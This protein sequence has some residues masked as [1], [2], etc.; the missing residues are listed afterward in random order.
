MMI[1]A[2][3]V[4]PFR[5]L[6]LIHADPDPLQ[7]VS[8]NQYQQM[9]KAIIRMILA[10]DVAYLGRDNRFP[11]ATDWHGIRTDRAECAGVARTRHHTLR[12]HLTEL[13]IFKTKMTAK[14]F[15]SSKTEDKQVLMNT[16]LHA[17]DQNIVARAQNVSCTLAVRRCFGVIF[18][19]VYFIWGVWGSV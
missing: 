8:E 10:T 13:T 18:G 6:C 9:R 12:S 4:C 5:F 16:V 17:A 14:D 7:N 1:S 19:G 2:R 3:T 11:T 15:P